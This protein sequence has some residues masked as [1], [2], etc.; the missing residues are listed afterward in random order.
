MRVGMRSTSRL[1]AK[2]NSTSIMMGTASAM[3]K[4]RASRVMWWSSLMKIARRRRTLIAASVVGQASRPAPLAERACGA[5]ASQEA[6][7]TTN[8]YGLPFF[9]LDHGDKDVFH[10][11]LDW[12]QALDVDELCD[13]G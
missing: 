2:P 13:E 4:L 8:S 11:R 7:P 5:L 3:P 12:L 10:R 9:G 1:S 6:C